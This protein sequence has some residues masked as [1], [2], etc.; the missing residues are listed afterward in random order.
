MSTLAA[1]PSPAKRALRPV[2]EAFVR[3][4]YRGR[5]RLCPV[6]GKA[7]RR[8]RA[9]GVTRDDRR[10]DAQCVYCGAL[11]R[12]RLTWLFFERR[13]GL[14]V[15]AP[16]QMLHV[17]PEKCFEP[18]FRRRLGSG[19]LTADLAAPQAMVALD[20]TDIPYPD[21][22]F[23]VIYCSHVLEHVADDRRAMREFFRV[24]S[25]D[26]WAVLLVPIEGEK[27]LED[28]A[29]TSPEDRRRLFGQFDH[30]R[31]Y[32]SDYAD[33]L[34][35]AGFEV[36]VVRVPDLVDEQTAVQMGLTA[37]SGDIYFCTKPL[38]QAAPA[39]AD[40]VGAA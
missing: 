11:E 8:F 18:R 28:S 10:E 21:G 3:V 12:H 27:T 15:G 30:V 17:A 39:E 19:Y 25:Q 20:I 9:F 16:A 23:D 36:E 32:G 14:F 2:R 34:R 37:A 22:H 26:G 38:A 13:T 6:C 7:A 33:R 29:I 4:S 1:L 31:L 35:E 24:L 5:G 40:A